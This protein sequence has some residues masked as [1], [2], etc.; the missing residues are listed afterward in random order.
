MK[1]STLHLDDD[2]AV[3]LAGHHDAVL[4]ALR[5]RAGCQ[6][7]MRGNELTL[8]GDPY[9]VERGE[10]LVGQLVEIAQQGRGL[11]PDMVGIVDTVEEDAAAAK[12]DD[13]AADRK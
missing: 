2:V 1:V 3:D 9:A 10:Q 13:A 5:E 4:D 12:A 8:S 7:T 11:T 6:I